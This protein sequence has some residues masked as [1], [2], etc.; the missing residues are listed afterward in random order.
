MIQKGLPHRGSVLVGCVV[1]MFLTALGAVQGQP[2]SV[3]LND[4]FSRSTGMRVNV[5]IAGARQVALLSLIVSTVWLPAQTNSATVPAQLSFQSAMNI[6]LK[7]SPIL[8]REQQN[9]VASRA[10]VQQARLLPNPEFGA[11]AANFPTFRA[12]PGISANTQEL[13]AQ[14]AQ[15]IEIGG[16]RG[17]RTRVADQGLAVTQSEL[18]NVVRQVKLDFKE[19]YFAVVLAKAQEQLSRE[20][21]DQFDGIVRLNEARFRQGEISGLELTRIR[22]ERF[23][24]LSDVLEA[25]LQVRNSKTALLELLGFSDLAPNFDVTESLASSPQIQPSLAQLEE[26]ALAARP[27]VIAAHQALERNRLE[28][29]YQK[30]LAIP[31]IA[32]LLGYSRI[33]GVSG[34]TFGV[35]LPLPFF[36]R[37][38]GGTARAT[39]QIEQQRRELNRVSLT[40]RRD[41]REAF[42]TLEVQKERV[43]LLESEYV[44]SAR[45]VRDTAQQSYRLGALDL[46]GLLDAERVYRDTVRGYNQALF[47][48]RAAIFL[49]EAAVGREL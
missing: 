17:K 12:G 43:R 23:R 25:Q 6:L 48:Y 20:N 18:Q 22:T 39:A 19:R 35:S 45:Q 27:D 40:V 8:L 10:D 37:N 42:Q 14:I 3:P 46:I 31:N 36:N 15:P 30:S 26:M 24:F 38:Q 5:N 49:L 33:S 44:P 16:K 41:V 28:L 34:A 21:L 32:P 13:F 4:I 2:T 47:D 1:W 9:V 11:N 7:Q 29:K